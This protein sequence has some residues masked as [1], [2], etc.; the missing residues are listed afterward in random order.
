MIYMISNHVLSFCSF[1]QRK[2]QNVSVSP[3]HS[4]SVVPFQEELIELKRNYATQKTQC[5]WNFRATLKFLAI[6]S[7][8]CF[9]P[10]PLC[11]SILKYK[12]A[13]IKN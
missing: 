2:P 3:S 13:N 9:S 4:V 12:I 6:A 10:L 11:K 1:L 7:Q 8:Q 5:S